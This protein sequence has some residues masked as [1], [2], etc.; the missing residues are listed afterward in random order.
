MKSEIG[1]QAVPNAVSGGWTGEK[2]AELL[3]QLISVGLANSNA[4]HLAAQVSDGCV[5]RLTLTPSLE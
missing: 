3:D 1:A 5:V 2:K 4:D